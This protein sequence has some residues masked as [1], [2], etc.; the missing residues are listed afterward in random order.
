MARIFVTGDKHG[1]YEKLE[2]FINDNGITNDDVI[3]ICGDHGTRYYGMKK[4]RRV[5]KYV[6]SLGP[7]FIMLRGNHDSRP[8]HDD[9]VLEHKFIANKAYCGTFWVDPEFPN[10]LYTDEFGWYRFG[11]KMCFVIGGAYSVDKWHRL[12]MYDQ[13]FHQYKWFY[14]EQLTP[15]E[16]KDAQELLFGYSG[17]EYYIFSHT[18]PLT[19]KPFDNLLPGIDQDLVDETM[20]RWL[21][22]IHLG[23][24]YTRWYC[25]HWHIE[26][27]I[28]RMRFLYEDVILFDEVE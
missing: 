20:E 19:Y 9:G 12:E 4:D 27:T 24:D 5:K 7:T 6:S 1:D 10:I 21:D 8:E 16:R 13:G 11:N 18:C 25:G 26:R 14:D 2:Y 17:T 15:Q 28:D 22:D 3:I 23:A